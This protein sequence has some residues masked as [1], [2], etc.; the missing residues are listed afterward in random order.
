LLRDT[1]RGIGLHLTAHRSQRRADRDDLVLGD[2]STAGRRG[3]ARQP[4]VT[5]FLVSVVVTPLGY[6]GWGAQNH[7]TLPEFST[8]GL[9]S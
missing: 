8:V 4:V 2:Q 9:F 7:W 5:F 1:S 6:A 3:R